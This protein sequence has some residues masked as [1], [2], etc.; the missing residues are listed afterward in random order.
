MSRRR[1]LG[2]LAQKTLQ[3]PDVDHR[4][5]DR[6]PTRFQLDELDPVARVETQRRRTSSGIVT[7][8]SSSSSQLPWSL[9]IDDPY[10]LL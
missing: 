3:G 8:P 1:R 5:S 2:R 9:L 10:A 7:C 4:R 6:K